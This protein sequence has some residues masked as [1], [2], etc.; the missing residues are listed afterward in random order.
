MTNSSVVAR[1]DTSG[2]LGLGVT[3]SASDGTLKFVTVGNVGN[4]FAG[5]N[6]GLTSYVLAG[7]Y[8]NAGWK[9][10]V[11]SSAV[12]RYDVGAG[13]HTWYNAA[14]GTAGNAITFTQAMTLDASGN[15][16][17]AS[18][19]PSTNL[20]IGTGSGGNGLGILLSRGATANLFEAYDGT[21]SFIAGTDSGNGSVKVGS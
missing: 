17:I 2:N 6:G 13:T 12:S 21:K 10:A 20:H 4:S 8:Y 18:T 14:S 16:G 15:L 11:S 9:Y 1:F 3:P 19:S 5:F 7:A